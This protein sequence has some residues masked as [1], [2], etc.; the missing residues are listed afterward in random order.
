[1]SCPTMK[2]KK[3]QKVPNVENVQKC[4]FTVSFLKMLLKYIEQYMTEYS[5]CIF[6]ALTKTTI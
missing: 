4:V 6:L 1:M 3:T 2:L 5:V